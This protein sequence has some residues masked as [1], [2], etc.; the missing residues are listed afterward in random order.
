MQWK[1]IRCRRTDERIKTKFGWWL[2]HLN[3]NN[4]TKIQPRNCCRFEENHVPFII[5]IC[6]DHKRRVEGGVWL[7]IGRSLILN[8]KGAAIIFLACPHYF[9]DYFWHGHEFMMKKIPEYGRNGGKQIADKY[10]IHG[11]WI[12][13]WLPCCRHSSDVCCRR[14]LVLLKFIFLSVWFT[15]L[16]FLEFF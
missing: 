16:W 1:N 7:P 15:Y 4:P 2:F 3:P 8:S 14:T 5:A 10:S 6:D 12:T 11:V 9:Y 13:K